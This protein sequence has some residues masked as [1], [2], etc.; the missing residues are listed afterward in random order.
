MVVVTGQKSASSD[1]REGDEGC[2]PV[3]TR[4]INGSSLVCNGP[5][6]SF[7][8]P[9]RI[10]V[11][12]LA[13]RGDHRSGRH[14]PATGAWWSV[15]LNHSAHHGVWFSERP[16]VVSAPVALVPARAGLA[17]CRRRHVAGAWTVADARRRSGHESEEA[18]VNGRPPVHRSRAGRPSCVSC[19]RIHRAAPEM[20]VNW[21][22]ALMSCTGSG[23]RVICRP[24]RAAVEAAEPWSGWQ[25]WSRWYASPHRRSPTPP[26]TRGEGSWRSRGTVHD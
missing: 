25:E 7:V 4:S 6:A 14:A 23:H 9:K 2:V 8:G 26:S 1:S 20:A 17:K 11:T 12:W 21:Q 19:A 16:I 3:T 24:V 22:V 15:A 13:P 10:T 5:V 18:V